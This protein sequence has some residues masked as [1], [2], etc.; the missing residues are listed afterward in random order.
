MPARTGRLEKRI[1]VEIPLRLSTLPNLADSEKTI[2]ENV[3]SCG[4]RLLTS[5]LL[6]RQEWL[7]V[8][9][10]RGSTTLQAQVV[11]C[12]GLPDGRFV[13]GLRLRDGSVDWGLSAADTD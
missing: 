1:N 3:S 9:L 10:T 6:R 8:T 11:Y 13:A 4:I 5:R 12:Y 2:T 7:E